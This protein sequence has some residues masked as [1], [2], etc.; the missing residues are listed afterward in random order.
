MKVS[1]RYPAQLISR[2][3][4]NRMGNN[5][6]VLGKALGCKEEPLIVMPVNMLYRHILVVGA[7]GSGKTRTTAF[8]INSLQ[9]A[10][11]YKYRIIVLDWHGEY[12]SLLKKYVYVNPYNAPVNI[13]DI[14]TLSWIETLYDVLGLSDPQAYVLQKVIEKSNIA[15]NN[16]IRKLYKL[17][18]EMD[19][20]NAKWLREVKYALLRRLA[21]LVYGDNYRLFAGTKDFL[22]LFKNR[23]T[24]VV[25][26]SMIRETRIKKIYATFIIRYVFDYALRNC[27]HD[28]ILVI[29]EA[30]NLM[31][32][33][34][35]LEVITRML[36]EI[37]KFGVGVIIVSQS[38]SGLGDDIMK[39]TASKIIHSIKSSVDLETISRSLV[40]DRE[41][42]SVVPYLEPGEAVVALPNYKKPLLVKI[43]DLPEKL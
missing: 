26:L 9:H 7:T 14:K 30:H 6:I 15:S 31:R 28:T 2:N 39:N 4:E 33:S 17:I 10:Y 24:Y 29:E 16:D 20:E 3:I 22:K 21:P 36:S 27:M 8:I 5:G 32:R 13:I 35:S 41:I 34:N 38:P 43:G 37:R 11:P 23:A 25:D 42:I 40:L 1:I 18:E 12:R 19:T